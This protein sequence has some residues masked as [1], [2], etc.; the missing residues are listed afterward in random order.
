MNIS[1]SMASTILV[2]YN[3]DM[4]TNTLKQLV[5][6]ALN[7]LKA[8]DIVVFDVRELTTVTDLMIICAGRSSRHVRSLANEVVIKAKSQHVKYIR[9]EGERESEWIIVD[10]ADVVVHVMQQQTRAFYHLEDLWQPISDSHT[11]YSCNLR[12][13]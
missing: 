9:T 7:D 11:N 8:I 2:G 10:L 3:S 4:Q 13:T 12:R 5:L 6:D 1:A